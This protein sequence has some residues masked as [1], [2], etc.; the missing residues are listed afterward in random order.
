MKIKNYILFITGILLIVLLCFLEITK[1]NLLNNQNNNV[2][3]TYKF[4][5]TD[6]ASENS[7]ENVYERVLEI[8][9][10]ID[11]NEIIND[12][13][14]S[15]LQYVSNS[16][17]TVA[18]IQN[19]IITAIT[20]GETEFI[21][22]IDDEEITLIIK[23]ESVKSNA[24]SNE[25]SA[26]QIF[27]LATQRGNY[28]ANEAVLIK[29]TNGKYALIDTSDNTYDNCA[30]LINRIKHYA[31]SQKVTLEYVI[32]SHFHTDHYLC[33]KDL[34]N[35]K[36]IK[37]ENVILKNTEI[38]K[39]IYIEQ[40][41]MSENKNVNVIRINGK[42][43]GYTK[44]LGTTKLLLYNTDDVFENNKT[45]Y[46]K[47]NILKFKSV[48]KTSQINSEYIYDNNKYIVIKGAGKSNYTTYSSKTKRA[49]NKLPDS[50]KSI[51]YYAHKEKSMRDSCNENS[52]SIAVLV[53][54]A[55]NGNDHRYAYL[56]NDLE[57]NGYPVW[58]AYNKKAERVIYGTGTSYS[59]TIKN[60]N[61]KPGSNIVYNAA[62]YR[63]AKDIK[64]KV[65]SNNLEKI[66]IYLQSHHGYNNA[67]DALETLGFD[68]A[69]PAN[70]PLYAIATNAN[71]PE[72]EVEDYLKANSYMNLYKATNNGKNNL[73]TGVYTHGIACNITV[74]GATSCI[75][76]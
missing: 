32:I 13:D 27:F 76:K 62:E 16:N 65:G 26:G 18:T 46:N 44:S 56:P 71:S 29:G 73:A 31:N 38:S 12:K 64:N 70:Y 1:S 30:V 51:I 7:L 53:D 75:G 8:G 35:D 19:N 4:D 21:Y 6:L 68:K 39:D 57:N 2:D 43:E 59:Y 40:K 25:K 54:F 20:E 72:T 52:N 36:S 34:L 69:R 67:K 41:R 42:K 63:V 47:I 10:T 17:D 11:I 15:K 24:L 37:V 61:I 60:G 14:I 74:S 66:T 23:V 3:M 5:E 55:I 22:N 9:D 45:C 49:T 48:K 33:Y 58:G 50:N 28:G